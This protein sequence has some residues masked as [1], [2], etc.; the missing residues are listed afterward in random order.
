MCKWVVCMWS[1]LVVAECITKGCVVPGSGWIFDTHTHTYRFGWIMQR[2]EWSRC[3][4][5]KSSRRLFLSKITNIKKNYEHKKCDKNESFERRCRTKEGKKKKNWSVNAITPHE[6]YSIAHI[7]AYLNMIVKYHVNREEK[8]EQEMARLT[9][10]MCVFLVYRC[11]FR[12]FHSFLISGI[13]NDAA[14]RCCCKGCVWYG[15]MMFENV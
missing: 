5:T 15:K 13:V 14:I 2:N 8:G 4:W 12:L 7:H 11:I 6:S 10:L 3:R 1:V 9:M